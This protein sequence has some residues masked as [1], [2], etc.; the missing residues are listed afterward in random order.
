MT[1][2]KPETTASSYVVLARKWRP[3]QFADIVGQ[4]HIVRTLV[5]AIRAERIHQA[6]LFTGSRGIGKTSIARIFAK[7]I[8]CQKAEN[9]TDGLRSCDGCPSCREVTLG[10]S[11]D[12]I[13]IDGASNNGVEAVREIRENAKYLPATGSRKIYIIDEVHML[14]TA[15]FNAL[16][17]TLEEPP[18]HVIFIFA[19]TEPHKIPAT[20]LSRCQ[21]FDYRRVTVPQIQTRIAQVTQAEGIEAEPGAL[22]LIARAAE[23]SMRDAL[24]LL[25]QVIAFSGNRIT[26]DTVRESVGLIE[27]QTI[28]GVLS[29]VFGRRPLEALERVEQAYQQ[30]HD[31]R[32]LTRTLIEFLHAAI[33]TKIGAPNSATLELSE[34]EWKELRTIADSRSLEELELIF[35]VLHQGLDWVARSP[36]PKV[37]LDVLLIKCATA[38][39]LVFADAPQTSTVPTAQVATPPQTVVRKMDSA[40][41]EAPAVTA[42][43]P[44]V[45]APT[46]PVSSAQKTWEGFIE[47]TRK[48]RPLLASILEHGNVSGNGTPSGDITV[49]FPPKHT[50]YRDQLQSRNYHEQ[51]MAFGRE[52]FGGPTRFTIELRDGGESP[53]EKR[54]RE[55]QKK[56]AD[57]R[58]AAQNHPVIVEAKALFGGELGPIR[59]T[60]KGSNE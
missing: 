6:Y 49:F 40:P 53:A 12:V 11:V 17:K 56:E 46:A 33:L 27:G 38:D 4:A 37:V 14:T 1:T 48:T 8:R 2:E 23:G 60:G 3:A 7:V 30:G 39:A 16:L 26:A 55:S 43:A 25:D 59:L 31:L 51:L 57:A 44:A 18:A 28:L 36:Q 15:A 21:R 22:A 58:S 42:A 45:K 9:T 54:E 50:H 52:Y 34:D 24:S 13:E 5:N 35:Q 41:A 47:H 32:V 20:I 19:T 29:G 10:N